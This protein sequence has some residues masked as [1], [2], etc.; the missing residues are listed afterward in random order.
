MISLRIPLNTKL[1]AGQGDTDTMLVV[2]DFFT[3]GLTSR[4]AQ[5]FVFRTKALTA[6][7]KNVFALTAFLSACDATDPA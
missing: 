3:A 2:T 4:N 7:Q 1:S 6:L 5:R